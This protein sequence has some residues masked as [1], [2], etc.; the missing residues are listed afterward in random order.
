MW[1]NE[2]IIYITHNILCFVK[3]DQVLT[4][5]HAP[6]LPKEASDMTTKYMQEQHG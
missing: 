5:I 1:D 3:Y 4:C 6:H 2:W